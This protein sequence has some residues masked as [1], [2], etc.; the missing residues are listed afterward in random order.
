MRHSGKWTTTHWYLL[1][2]TLAFCVA[3][4]YLGYTAPPAA[5]GSYRVITSRGDGAEEVE[6]IP[7][8][9]ATADELQTL[10]GIGPT[11]AQR[12]VEYR[13]H[14]GPF[15]GPEELTQVEGIGQK[16]A[17]EIADYVTWEDGNEDTGGG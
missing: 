11:L 7:I 8:N 2:L 5:R 13:D 3:A 1:V 16:T 15:S 17:E 12:I 9:T 10:K 14:H 4:V 6:K